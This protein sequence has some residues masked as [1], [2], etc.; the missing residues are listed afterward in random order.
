MHSRFLPFPSAAVELPASCAVACLTRH[1]RVA[2]IWGRTV[3]ERDSAIGHES[4]RF[5]MP[6]QDCA[7]FASQ[8]RDIGWVSRRKKTLHLRYCLDQRDR[9]RQKNPHTQLPSHLTLKVLWLGRDPEAGAGAFSEADRGRDGRGPRR[10]TDRRQ[11]AR[12]RSRVVRCAASG[13]GTSC[14][15]TRS[16]GGGGGGGGRSRRRA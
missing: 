1:P 10:G 5:A 4:P 14:Y 11:R 15:S 16:G 7:G 3:P 12:G 13:I 8:F 6:C 2:R 9:A